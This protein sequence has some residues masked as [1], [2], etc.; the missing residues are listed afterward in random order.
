MLNLLD[1]FLLPAGNC[2]VSCNYLNCDIILATVGLICGVMSLKSVSINTDFAY[3]YALFYGIGY[4]GAFAM[5]QLTVAEM[6]RGQDFKKV[7]GIV[8]S[9]DSIGGFAGVALMGYLRTQNGNYNS[10]MSVLLAVCIGALVLA[11]VLRQ[12][13]K[14]TILYNKA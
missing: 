11:L 6:Y 5:I 8:N 14:K 9:F 2:V 4:S 12:V 3:L 13:R 7:L 1:G 10:A